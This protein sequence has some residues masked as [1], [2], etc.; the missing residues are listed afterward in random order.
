[1]ANIQNL[2][3]QHIEIKELLNQFKQLFSKELTDSQIDEG[4]KLVNTL[5]GKL[6]IHMNTEDRFLYPVLSQSKNLKLREAG[7]AFSQEMTDIGQAFN[8]YKLKFNTQSKIQ[9]DK[10]TFIEESK[11][12]IQLIEKRMHNEDTNLYPEFAKE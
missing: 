9:A 8:Q 10:N 7:K 2:E 5:A 6:K 12:V 11:Q 3:R 4:V 1:M